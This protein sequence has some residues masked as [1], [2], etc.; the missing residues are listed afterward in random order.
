MTKAAGVLNI[1]SGAT[2]LLGAIF[3]LIF[4]WLGDGIL[5]ILWYGLVGTLFWQGISALHP[6]VYPLPPELQEIAAIPVMIL[7]ILAIVGGICAL[8][9]KAW[10]VAFTGS[11][12]AALVTWF[13]GVPAIILTVMSNKRNLT[14]ALKTES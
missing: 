7:S 9:R 2:H 11:I 5:N 14:Q 8:K 1:I 13:L 10:S 3:I 4:G 12:C 6:L